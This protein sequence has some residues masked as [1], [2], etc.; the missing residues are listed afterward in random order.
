MQIPDPVPGLVIRYSYLW[1]HEAKAGH[2]EGSKDRPCAVLLATTNKAGAKMVPILPVTHT[3]PSDTSL[4]VE[5]PHATKVRLGLDDDRAVGAV[6]L[7][8]AG[9]AVKPIGSRLNDRELICEGL[10]R[11]DA[12]IADAGH[13]VLLEWQDQTVPMD[14]R[15]FGEIVG[16]IDRD[17]LPL[18]EPKYRSRR[19]AV[20]TDSASRELTGI[21]SD[22]IDGDIVL[23]SASFS[24][25]NDDRHTQGERDARGAFA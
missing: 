2:E 18:L 15:I 20:V 10:A 11:L 19:G 21:D 7:L 1:S 14:R 12:R 23:A 17:V 25:S 16:H 8:K 4:A 24:A 6:R 22:R 13:A 3:P 5:I 9:M